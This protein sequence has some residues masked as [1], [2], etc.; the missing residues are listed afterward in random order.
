MKSKIVDAAVRCFERY[1]VQRTTMGDIADEAGIARQSVYRAFESRSTLIMH[2]ITMLELEI[3]EQIGT[4]ISSYD[5]VDEAIVEGSMVSIATAQRHGLLMQLI[6][7]G[8]DHKIDEFVL[9]G[10]PEV[11]ASL[12]KYWGPVYHR[13]QNEG[14]F[15]D[16]L[17]LDMLLDWMRDVHAGLFNHS[18]YSDEKRRQILRDFF[19]RSLRPS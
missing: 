15:R 17:S 5:D 9:R 7:N 14:K 4:T 8:T 16:D 3:L 6:A 11:M 2:I 10:S 13:G 19:L 1:G 18:D 12:K